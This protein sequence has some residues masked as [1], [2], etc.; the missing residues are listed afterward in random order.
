L[1][2]DVPPTLGSIHTDPTKLKDV[3]RNLVANALKFTLEG[4]VTVAARAEQGGVTVS[5]SDTGI[6]IPPEVAPFIYEPFHQGD[7]PMTRRFGGV[8]LGLYLVRR[9]LHLLGGTIAMETTVGRGSKFT[10]SIPDRPPAP[11]PAVLPQRESRSSEDWARGTRIDGE[12]RIGD[13]RRGD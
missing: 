12:E 4:S 9:L 11:S 1:I 8:G 5:V 3:V 7:S 6:G 10:I 2:L 13:E